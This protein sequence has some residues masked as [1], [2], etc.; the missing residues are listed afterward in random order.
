M[1]VKN[2][3]QCFVFFCEIVAVVSLALTTTV[4]TWALGDA[5]LAK[6]VDEYQAVTCPEASHVS[7]ILMPLEAV[8]VR[9]SAKAPDNPER[10]LIATLFG[11]AY[12][13]AV[14]ENGFQCLSL[15]WV[16]LA[17]WR[18]WGWATQACS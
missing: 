14:G 1:G 8:T 6:C 7:R 4:G 17:C 16:G 3:Q 10:P 9:L 13:P 18:G 5:V 12:W 2:L 11:Q 15:R